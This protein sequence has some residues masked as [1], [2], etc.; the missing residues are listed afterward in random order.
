MNYT[1]H[2]NKIAAKNLLF[3]KVILENDVV[4]YVYG[5]D[6]SCART[7]AWMLSHGKNTK[8]II[9]VDY[10]SLPHIYFK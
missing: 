7:R 9:R 4:L 10:K 5:K 3:F 1:E 6:E 8:E 2:N